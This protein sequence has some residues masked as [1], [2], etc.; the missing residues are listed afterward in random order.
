MEKKIRSIDHFQRLDDVQIKR[1]LDS[2]D[3][4]HYQAGEQILSAEVSPNFYSFLIS[5]KW[6]MQRQ[7]VGVETV[8]EWVDD[9]PGN[10]HGG[11]VLID[12]IAPPTV[13]AET[14]C[15][16]IHI[17]TNLLN[18]LAAQ[19]AH[20]AVAMLRGVSGGSTMLYEHATRQV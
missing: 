13:K 11:I 5:G 4:R 14:D 18:E 3:V 19:N 17:P 7:I 10:W 16:V 15:V 6:W 2:S 8:K 9:R 1:L 20:L 12:R